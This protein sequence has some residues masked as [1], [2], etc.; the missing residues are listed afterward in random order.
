MPFQYFTF[1]EF[2]CK[3]TGE[4][5]MQTRFIEQ[6]DAL[7]HECGFPFIIVSGYR[8]PRHSKELVK[9][10]P[11]MHSKGLAADIQISGGEQR[12][13][14]VATALEHGFTGIGVAKTFIHVDLRDHNIVM[15]VYT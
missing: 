9:D 11:G 7:R 6:L 12:Y 4:N 10:E 5:E 13:E 2:D 8:S 1:S 15:W 14:L 3:E